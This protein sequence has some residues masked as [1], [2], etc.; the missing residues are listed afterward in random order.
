[1][2]FADARVLLYYDFPMPGERSRSDDW[3]QPA[4]R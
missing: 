2:S 3:A 4:A 1:M